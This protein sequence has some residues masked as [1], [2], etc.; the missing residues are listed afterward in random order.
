[1]N[2]R[3]PLGIRQGLRVM[4]RHWFELSMSAAVVV[5]VGFVSVFIVGYDQAMAARATLSGKV[6]GLV[7]NTS[8]QY[9]RALAYDQK[10]G[11]F[12]YN[13]GYQP[14]DTKISQGSGPKFTAIIPED[15]TKDVVVTDPV[16]QLDV[17]FKPQ[18]ELEKGQQQGNHVVYPI[19][20]RNASKVYTMAGSG[21]KEDI[22]LHAFQGDSL[23]FSYQLTLP[24]ET[25]ARLSDDGSVGVYGAEK[26]LLGAV[27]TGSDADAQLLAKAKQKSEKNNLLFTIPAP[28]AKEVS[29]RSSVVRTVWRLSG[30]TLTLEAGNLRQATYPLTL[31]P[32]IYVT[33]AADF[34]RGNNESNIDFDTTNNLI[35][36]GR[37]TGA[38]MNAWSPVAG[39]QD[40]PASLWN[41]GTVVAGGYIYVIGGSTGTTNQ[42]TVYWAKLDN[43][44]YTITS[45]NPGDGTC[46]QWCTN[47]AYNLPG[48][49]AGLAVAAY[50]GYLYAV[51]G[52]DGTP[53][54]SNTVY[55][56]KLG[57]NGEPISWASTTALG[58]E[59]SY[60]SAVAYQNKLY[61]FGGQ[62]NGSTGGVTGAG[63]IQYGTINPDG[64]VTAWTD[65]TTN[66]P[67]AR[68]GHTALEYNGYFYLVGGASG[69][70]TQN[71]VEYVKIASSGDITS[72]WTTT[73]SF[74]AARAGMGGNIAAIWGGYMYVS[75]GCTTVTATDCG[76][77]Y[78]TGT[79]SQSGTTITGAGGATWTSAMVGMVITFSNGL[80]AMI[81]SYT[82]ATHLEAANDEQTVAS[83]SY[84]I[85]LNDMTPQVASINA[86]GSI[87]AWRIITLD[88]GQY[89]MAGTASQSGTA[90]SGASTAWDIDMIGQTLTY[91]NNTSDIIKGQVSTTSMI[92]TTSRTVSSQA[93]TITKGVY[94]TGG[95]VTQSGTTITGAGGAAFTADMVG[96]TIT[97]A[98]GGANTAELIT[99]YTDATHI[100]VAA[101]FS[102]TI[103]S[104][105]VFVI[106]DTH[107]RRFSA[108]LVAWRS[109]L[110][111]IGGCA[112]MNGSGGCTTVTPENEY[113]HINNDG[114]VSQK[115]VETT[116]PTAGTSNTAGTVGRYSNGV[117]INNGYIYTVGGCGST[118]CTAAGA[119]NANL[120]YATIGSDG[121]I[122][123]NG[124]TGCSGG[125]AT[126]CVVQVGL[127]GTTGLG[128]FGITVY[129]N[130]I[131]VAGGGTGGGYQTHY[132]YLQ[133]NA[134][135]SP[136]G[137][138]ADN[139]GTA[140]TVL[141]GS[142]GY[143]FLFTRAAST[144]TGNIYA[145]GGC[146]GTSGV[147]C[148]GYAVTVQKCTITNSTRAVSGCTTTG[149]TQLPTGHGI[150][151]SSNAIYQD[152]IYL[153]GGADGTGAAQTDTCYYAQ[154][155]DSNNIVAAP[156]Q[157]AWVTT[158]A[159]LPQLRRRGTAFAANGYV[160]VIGGH[161]GSIGTNG[162]TLHDVVFAKIDLTTGN[163]TGTA[164]SALFDTSTTTVTGR[165]NL[166]VAAA[167]GY[168]YAIG[169]CTVGYP[170]SNCT[171][172]NG[173]AESIQVYNNY[174]GSPQSYTAAGNLFATDRYGAGAVAVNGYLYVAG[175]CSGT[176]DCQTN[177]GTATFQGDSA[178][179]QIN[180]DGSLPGWSTGPSFPT[181]ATRG[182]GCMVSAGGYLY[183]IGG[184]DGTNAGY[185]QVYYSQLVNGVPQAWATS[186]TSF[187]AGLNRQDMGCAVFNNRIYVVG[188]SDR[189][190]AY[191]STVY[192]SPALP[193]GGDVTSWTSTTAFTTGRSG[194]TVIA[195]GQT[196][197]VIGGYDGTN[198]LMDVQ[199]ADINSSTGAIGTWAYGPSLPQVVRQGTGFAANGYLYVFGGR[200]AATTCTNNTYVA[201]INGYPAGST[202]RYGIGG[203]SQTIVSYS[204]NRF[205][206]GAAYSGGRAYLLGGFCNA[207]LTGANRVVYGALQAQPQLAN[208][209]LSLDT[210]TDVFPAKY[211][212]NGV[213]NGTG[214]QWSLKYQSSNTANHVWGTET[215]AGTVTLGTPSGQMVY[216][217]TNTGERW[218]FLNILVDASQAFGYPEDVTRGPTINDITI[219]FSTDPGKRLH[220][221]KTFTGGLL[222]PLDA[223]F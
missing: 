61:L 204:G 58:T 191:T 52:Y 118:P 169:G 2:P 205:G 59:R 199:Y 12:R 180:A 88:Q 48:A 81:T 128:A 146:T 25:E 97:I 41:H 49:R 214:A 111:N 173:V 220:H 27:S 36:K 15:G 148:S 195:Y 57:A 162:S 105:S 161:D 200:S 174:S 141:A 223:P 23:E 50:N 39:T 202:S 3:M 222:Q 16:S 126:W 168:F 90:I 70:T 121:A 120:A 176:V 6:L 151:I 122:V 94:D 125:A 154:I 96:K 158:T 85:D 46:S 157:S 89:Y 181:A 86:D 217:D 206:T 133:L 92:A 14:S 211:L 196:L 98:N 140:G 4:R 213:D 19:A 102:Q 210:D 147:G 178:Y 64:T 22:I 99:A 56:A 197:Y 29:G 130:T 170:P 66:M 179:V 144:T 45:P 82:D 73:S 150:A 104:A 183:Y 193:S 40:I 164:N 51:A 76:S 198:Y 132:F 142:Y 218:Y 115:R 101:A 7:G 80:S 113:A 72:S 171:G 83:G 186:G 75:N 175:G 91:A 139:G 159:H 184:R 74:T 123:T 117:V 21:M 110:Y 54:R 114:D 167:N 153:C 209:S 109:T 68:W 107:V 135:G 60:G 47:T 149:Q 44:T 192:Y 177:P 78:S 38:R 138:F 1:M 165:W 190:P 160:Y 119:M 67:S 124:V 5:A 79:A 71:S 18:F 17:R 20:H 143:P 215:D 84:T 69:T 185:A 8:Q 201:S 65:A 87:S 136:N 188:G 32:T 182:F 106:R 189:T 35:Q 24:A 34:M 93:Y 129:N 108:G 9:A 26:V 127:N 30:N 37:L 33:S 187:G 28:F 156:S 112:A 137:T 31:D 43:S 216:A 203:W 100:T 152:Y 207:T 42:A 11:E 208:Y 53:A 194:A 13:A 134:D 103:A 10:S 63:S 131:Y 62:S 219:E 212:M 95:T 221:G 116:M 77:Y 155:N 145:I 55:Y 172:I 166:G 163:L